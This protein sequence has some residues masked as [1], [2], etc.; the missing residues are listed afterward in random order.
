M[1]HAPAGHVILTI[2]VNDAELSELQLHFPE[3]LRPYIPALEYYK[4][5]RGVGGTVHLKTA[6][7]IQT[8]R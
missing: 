1:R 3:F 7:R 4:H 5:S 2:P 8:Q 6:S